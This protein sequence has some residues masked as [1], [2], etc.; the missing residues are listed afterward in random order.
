M[1]VK[2][3]GVRGWQG[4]DASIAAWN[5]MLSHELVMAAS[6]GV[7]DYLG[8][9][10]EEV[11]S[12]PFWGGQRPGDPL[13]VSRDGLHWIGEQ[14]NRWFLANVALLLLNVCVGLDRAV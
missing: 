1:Q 10:D 12:A 3:H 11:M 4:V 6:S 14:A 2:Y 13:Q 5:D 7:V 9:L 8:Q